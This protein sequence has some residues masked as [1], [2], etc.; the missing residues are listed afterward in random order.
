MRGIEFRNK[1]LYNMYSL[2]RCNRV[3]VLKIANTGEE[4]LLAE[5]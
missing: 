1:G 2:P 4:K 5:C 3:D